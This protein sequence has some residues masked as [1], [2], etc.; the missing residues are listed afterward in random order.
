MSRVRYPGLGV[1]VYLFKDYKEEFEYGDV[2]KV[3]Y[4]RRNRKDFRNP[5]EDWETREL[6]VGCVVVKDKRYGSFI[7]ILD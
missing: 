7:F 3:E 5:R 6:G 2:R 1:Y 4:L